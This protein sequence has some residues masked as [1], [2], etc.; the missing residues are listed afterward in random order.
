HWQRARNRVLVQQCHRRW[1]RSATVGSAYLIRSGDM[2]V[3]HLRSIDAVRGWAIFGVIIAHVSTMSSAGPFQ[4]LAQLGLRGVQLFFSASAL[5]LF[6]AFHRRKSEPASIR[7]YFIRRFFR[8][9]PFY[10]LACASW[11]AY[12]GTG[13][14]G[15]A[16]NGVSRLT[17]LLTPL[18]LNGWHPE[19]F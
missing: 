15:T 19:Q 9:A 4:P 12:L 3:E 1:R 11:L 10:Y 6:L 8:I 13:P 7:N 2:D 5:T 18:F 17:I 16:P 14:N